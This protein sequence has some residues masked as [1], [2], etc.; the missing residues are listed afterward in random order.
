MTVGSQTR[1][2]RRLIMAAVVVCSLAGQPLSAQ[3]ARP[4]TALNAVPQ[5]AAKPAPALATEAAAR[6]GVARER[7]PA[8]VSATAV[9]QPSE[10]TVKWAII[11]GV[12]VLA[13][14]LI[15]AL[16]D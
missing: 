3:A 15:V 6:R 2:L 14:L 11:I 12:A 4:E 7:A 9:A 16:A 13:A 5:E 8:T 1:P 10:N